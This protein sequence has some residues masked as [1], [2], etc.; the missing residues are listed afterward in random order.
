MRALGH[1]VRE[2]RGGA[3]E[4]RKE[5]LA[6]RTLVTRSRAGE[7]WTGEAIRGGVVRVMLC[8]R[9]EAGNPCVCTHPERAATIFEDAAYYGA[10]YPILLIVTLEP[11]GYRLELVKAVLRPNPKSPRVIEKHR[12]DVIV[13]YAGWIL[14]IMTIDSKR[15]G[16]RVIT[17]EAK[18]ATQPKGTVRGL[19]DG[20]VV[21]TAAFGSGCIVRETVSG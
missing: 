5:H 16:L 1:F 3:A 14:G 11:P 12:V 6:P 4:P 15:L 2:K 9:I 7:I 13:T 19:R 18:I 21:K 17:M 10:R 8:L 20:V